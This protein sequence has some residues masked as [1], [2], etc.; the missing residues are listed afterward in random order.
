MY[1]SKDK[2]VSHPNHYQSKSGL[3]VIDVISAFTED[4][5]GMEAIATGHAIR[6]ILR[7]KLKNGVQDLEKAMWYIQYLIDHVKDSDTKKSSTTQEAK[8]TATRLIKEHL[9]CGGNGVLF[10]DGTHS[11]KWVGLCINESE[12][13]FTTRVIDSAKSIAS[14]LTGYIS[15]Q[16]DYIT[17]SQLR[18][19]AGLEKCHE[20]DDVHIYL[21]PETIAFHRL[22]SDLIRVTVQ[23]MKEDK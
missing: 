6:Y 2:M 1:E 7:W 23:K 21:L 3:E 17:L 22:E 14:M 11:G 20:F 18:S 9:L 13:A 10:W 5:S 19:I 8:S 4:L 16:I 12:V 15:S